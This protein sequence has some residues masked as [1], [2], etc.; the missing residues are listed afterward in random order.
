MFI[1]IHQFGWCPVYKSSKVDHNF[2][3]LGH[4]FRYQNVFLR[5]EN[6]LFAIMGYCP[7]LMKNANFYEIESLNPVFLSELYQT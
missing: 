5:F 2:M 3:K 4:N 7:L 6:G 1:L